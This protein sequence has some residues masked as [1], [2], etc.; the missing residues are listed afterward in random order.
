MPKKQFLRLFLS[1]IEV[2]NGAQ[3]TTNIYPTFED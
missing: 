3:V 2:L 1:L